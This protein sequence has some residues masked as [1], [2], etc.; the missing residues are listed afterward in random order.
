MDGGDSAEGDMSD[1]RM[2]ATEADKLWQSWCDEFSRRLCKELDPYFEQ[3][4]ARANQAIQMP[5]PKESLVAGAVDELYS[6]KDGA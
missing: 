5:P 3:V 2:T 4:L 6:T 1:E